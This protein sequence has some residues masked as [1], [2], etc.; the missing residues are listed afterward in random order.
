MLCPHERYDSAMKKAVI[1]GA[2]IIA[3]LVIMFVAW[4]DYEGGMGVPEA[5]S[6]SATTTPGIDF[7]ATTTSTGDY[8]VTMLSSGVQKGS[9]TPDYTSP[10]KCASDI[11]TEECAH[12]TAI[13]AN[14]AKQ[15][16]ASPNEMR[17][18]I[19]LGTTRKDVNDFTGAAD[20][21]NYVAMRLGTTSPTPYANL[22][23]L[24]AN[25]THE[26]TKAIA[27]YEKAVAIYPASYDLHLSLARLYKATG[28]SAK[29]QA[30]YSAAADA[31]TKA[32]QTALAAQITAEAA[33]K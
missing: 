23:D 27:A 11:S 6:T 8:K 4:R 12:F 13:A 18:W 1:I 15:I 7:G 2:A 28:Q 33:G 16:T 20:A 10:L 3:A 32:G 29:A 19:N 26:N 14:L 25:F 21:W 31:A 5:T 30:Q 9:N 17:Y 24:Y 22:G